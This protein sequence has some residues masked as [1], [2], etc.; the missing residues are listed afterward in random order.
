MSCSAPLCLAPLGNAL[1]YVTYTHYLHC[2][3]CSCLSPSP[4]WWSLLLFFTLF[5][6]HTL[7]IRRILIQWCLKSHHQGKERWWSLAQEPHWQ[8]FA[9]SKKSFIQFIGGS[10]HQ[11][12]RSISQNLHLIDFVNLLHIASQTLLHLRIQSRVT[13]LY[14]IINHK[15]KPPFEA[16]S[17]LSVRQSVAA[18]EIS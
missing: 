12:S 6:K 5:A 14:D 9:V 10:L 7:C 18:H 13:L 15:H 8:I 4:A 3:Y 1:S 17:L 16:S 2:H 11:K